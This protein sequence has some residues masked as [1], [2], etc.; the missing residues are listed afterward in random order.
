MRRLALLLLALSPPL[1]Y[2][3]SAPDYLRDLVERSRRQ[4]LAAEKQWLRLV[5][6]KKI[7]SG[8]FKSEADGRAFFLSPR[9]R[10]DPAAEL[11]AT[12]AGFLQEEMADTPA[13][14][15]QCQF[16]ARFIWLHSKLN[17]DFDR[18]R[19]KRCTRFEEFWNRLSAKSI[20]LV[21]SSYYLNNPAS[22]FG[23]TFLRTNKT[24]F[25]YEGKRFELLDYGI[26]YSATVDTSNALVYGFKGLTGLFPGHFNYYPYFFKVR[27][28]NDYESRDLWEYDLNLNQ[29]QVNLL[30]AHLWE[31][32]FTYFDYYYV[33]ANCAYHILTALEAANPDLELSDRVGWFVI[34]ANSVKAVFANQGL[35]RG[36]HYRPSIHTQFQ[37][38][39]DRLSSAQRSALAAVVGD[40]RAPLPP[41]MG[42]RESVEI[43]DV[44][45]DYADLRY[46]REL[47]QGTDRQAL[48]FKQRLLERRSEILIPSE[49][50]RIEP[51]V[52][53]QPQLGHGTKR[54]ELGGGYSSALG[55]YG[56]LELRMGLHDLADPHPGYPELSEIEF[57]PA[58]IRY[59]SDQRSVWLEDFSIVRVISLSS[60]SRFD[61][62][63]SWNFRL[64]VTTVRDGG[65][66]A[67]AAGVFEIGGGLARSWFGSKLT[68][69]GFAQA[70]L[71]GSPP[72]HGKFNLPLRLGAGPLVGTRIRVGE[73]FSSVVS[74]SY[75]YL[76]ETQPRWTYSGSMVNRFHFGNG[77]SISLEVKKVPQAWE[78]LL[79]PVIYF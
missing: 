56:T 55:P 16:P 28:Y 58:R 65:C 1:A 3:G 34:P 36:V 50:L 43:L 9:G 51:P 27:E 31:L 20:T 47:I 78:G 37:D 49:Q 12:L 2:S 39:L 74:G 41:A 4:N 76:L 8:D 24:D 72:L 14:H 23:H 69:F 57:F 26:D 48:E 79:A 30:V 66:D 73:R 67:C 22:A 44:A 40:Y 33:T 35:V 7:Y 71:L 77:F 29:A 38:R 11:E 62:K 21:F 19:P 45:L 17:F 42:P 46:A 70:E 54:A 15:P 5:H 60:V 6:Y 10:T 64:G 59:N 75:Q 13:Q 52:L 68:L 18:L 32:G 53:Q 63:P 25:A 61:T